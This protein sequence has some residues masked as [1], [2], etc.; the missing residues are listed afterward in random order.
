MHMSDSLPDKRIIVIN[1]A[2]QDISLLHEDP[3]TEIQYTKDFGCG[4]DVHS[5]F[6][7]VSVLV[8]R[9]LSVYEYRKDF[10]TDWDSLAEAKQWVF[11]VIRNNSQPAVD[12]EKLFSIVV[13]AEISI[14][15][16]FSS[17]RNIR[18]SSCSSLT[19]FRRESSVYASTFI[20]IPHYQSNSAQLT[21]P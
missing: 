7:Q 1:E 12:P 4:L 19:S 13:Y 5:K 10:K 2:G 16:S 20:N 8:K 18:F 15:F 6:I 3:G 21:F 17:S 14:F 9:N 11:S